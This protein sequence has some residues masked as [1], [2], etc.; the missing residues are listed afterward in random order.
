MCVIW[1]CNYHF[2][3]YFVCLDY[4]CPLLNILD[5][6]AVYDGVGRTILDLLAVSIIA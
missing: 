2:S 1:V 6:P 5:R 3:N 4:P